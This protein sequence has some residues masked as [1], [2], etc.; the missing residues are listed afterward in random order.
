MPDVWELIYWGSR[1]AGVAANDDDHDGLSNLEEY[2]LG[3]CPLNPD[4]D[5]D[6]LDD[7]MEATVCG[8]SPILADTDR[9]GMKD[10]YEIANGF[11]AVNAADALA[12]TDGDGV[13]NLIESIAKTCPT[14][15]AD[16]PTND[17]V[18]I[19][20]SVGEPGVSVSRSERCGLAINGTLVLTNTEFGMITNATLGFVRGNAYTVTVAHLQHNAASFNGCKRQEYPG[21]W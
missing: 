18:R 19:T 6:G 2:E 12:D 5:G 16:P 11:S 20:L 4:T 17:I 21:G 14:N 13:V 8:T 3:A 7:R 10:G 9:D 1:T 15:A